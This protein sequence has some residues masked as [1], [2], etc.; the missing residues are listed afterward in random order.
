MAITKEQIIQTAEA[1]LV[2]GVNPSMAAVRER[3]GGGS[4]ATISPVLRDWK[5]RHRSEAI[6]AQE[7][8]AEAI[9][10]G[11]RAALA[12][13]REAMQQA[14]VRIEDTERHAAEFIQ[15]AK[16]E[17][18]EALNEVERLEQQLESLRAQVETERQA[19][20]TAEQ[21]AMTLAAEKA[22]EVARLDEV[23]FQVGLLETSLADYRRQ[24]EIAHTEAQE[25]QKHAMAA[26][27]QAAEL[28]GRLSAKIDPSTPAEAQVPLSLPSAEKS[29][30]RRKAQPTISV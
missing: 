25:A 23:R 3:L 30:R 2:E 20:I 4:F 10:A 16:N 11:Q 19:R 14:A 17:R 5:E 1:L 13:W 24:L 21:C 27:E 9:A 26:K 12:I 7:A 22:A 6:A 8:P 15:E 28:R 18:D 29:Q